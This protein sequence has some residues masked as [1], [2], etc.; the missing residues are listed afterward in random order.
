MM[1]G[2]GIAQAV[3][4]WEFVQVS[5]TTVFAFE[6]LLEDQL[7]QTLGVALACG[8]HCGC[9]LGN[10]SFKDGRTQRQKETALPTSSNNQ[11]HCP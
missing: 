1:E 11:L 10:G 4:V 8:R 7:G 5:L 3:G 2:G 9:K 6:L